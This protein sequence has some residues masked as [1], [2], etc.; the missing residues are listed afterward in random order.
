MF[1]SLFLLLLASEAAY[2]SRNDPVV[3]LPMG[4]IRGFRKTIIRKNLNVFLGIPFA[5]PPLGDL[6]YK[7]PVEIDKYRKE[8]VADTMPKAC[9]QIDPFTP[10]GAEY[11]KR[12]N[13][14]EDCLYLNIWVPV[15]KKL[16]TEPK[17]V[18]VWIYGGGF[19]QGS[20]S[21]P[22]YNGQ[23][24]A[25]HGDVIVASMNY[26]VGAMGFLNCATRDEPGNIGL[27]DQALALRWIRNNIAYFGGNPESMTIFGES[28][29]GL[30]VG[31]HLTSPFS[32]GLF[33]RAI[34][35]SGTANLPVYFDYEQSLQTAQRFARKANCA[36]PNLNIIKNPNA[37]LNCLRSK[38]P[39]ELSVAEYEMR[40]NRRIY[41]Q[42]RPVIGED[43]L[44][45]RNFN[46][47]VPGHIND[48]NIMIGITAND[49]QSFVFDYFREFIGNPNVTKTMAYDAMIPFLT[50]IGRLDNVKEKL[51][52]YFRGVI[53]DDIVEVKRAMGRVLT[54]WMFKCP[55][56]E[57]ADIFTR[58]DN[59]V[60]FYYY[61]HLYSGRSS[62]SDGGWLEVP[63][64]EEVK[65][66]FGLIFFM[67][68]IPHKF[69]YTRNEERFS[70]ELIDLWSSYA[71]TG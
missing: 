22:W 46:P 56:Q 60:S 32:K 55:S 36:S 69:N 51:D 40:G 26:R 43:F 3:N 64:F 30:S 33:K 5:K 9:F 65:F 19:T 12:L 70:L 27:Y 34:M 50:E 52:Y 57:I 8:I 16:N 44:P 20:T 61:N 45:Y 53:E 14:S 37:I 66:L 6:R 48:R 35:Q 67:D 62:Y 25:A 2:S 31:F 24:I 4:R 15:T 17:S 29:G 7:K 38:S 54:D 21:G 42:F 23:I 39:E 59:R 28:A 49:G 41:A 13:M 11:Y 68:E 18:L 58:L 10:D 71:K 47:F 1:A 63:H